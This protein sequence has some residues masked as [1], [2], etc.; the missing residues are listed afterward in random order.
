MINKLINDDCF[1]ILPKIK[2][3]SAQLIFTGVPDL[4]DLGMSNKEIIVYE[5]FID[6]ALK[7]FA[8]IIKDNG[9]I[10]MCQSDRK[11]GGQI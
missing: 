10:A 2:K 1:K 6:I 8:R 11:M 9:F 3:N 5:T 4:N 7:Q